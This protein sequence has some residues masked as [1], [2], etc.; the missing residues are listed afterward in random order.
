MKGAAFL[1]DPVGRP[2]AR[3]E[4]DSAGRLFSLTSRPAPIDAGSPRWGWTSLYVQAPSSP[5]GSWEGGVHGQNHGAHWSPRQGRGQM[6][7]EAESA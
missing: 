6:A 3:R 1:R 7:T 2:A 5:L 4:G